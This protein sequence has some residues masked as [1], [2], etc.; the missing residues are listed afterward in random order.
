MKL[1]CKVATLAAVILGD[2]LQVGR[3]EPCV[4]DDYGIASNGFYQ[5]AVVLL[6]ELGIDHGWLVG[7]FAVLRT[8][9]RLAWYRAREGWWG[10]FVG[11][12]RPL[13]LRQT[14][15]AGG[16]GGWN[17]GGG[18]YRSQDKAVRSNMVCQVGVGS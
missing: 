7:Q 17:P 8:E 3:P 1:P 12:P 5:G 11:L 18:S 14:L 15:R 6:P 9:G 13:G 10:C 4:D 2:I 16:G